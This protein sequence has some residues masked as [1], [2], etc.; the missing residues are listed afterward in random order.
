[1]PTDLDILRA[2]RDRESAPLTASELA[3]ASGMPVERVAI[4]MKS[5]VSLR[6]VTRVS[7]GGDALYAVRPGGEEALDASAG[8][9][10]RRRGQTG[11]APTLVGE[12]I[13]GATAVARRR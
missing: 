8:D 9:V 10:T 4:R 13:A 11:A 5:L 1:V 6:Y 2:L 7:D 3:E 12:P